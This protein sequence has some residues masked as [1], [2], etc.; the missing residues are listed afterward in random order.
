[1]MFFMIGCM[2][3]ALAHALF[4][5]LPCIASQEEFLTGCKLNSGRSLVPPVMPA[6]SSIILSGN[7]PFL[8]S[9]RSDKHG[10]KHKGP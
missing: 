7:I 6:I 3:T 1:M 8:I 2:S 10:D 5:H 4:G 9:N